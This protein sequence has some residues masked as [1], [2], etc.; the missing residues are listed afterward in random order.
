V[1]LVAA[2]ALL[3]TG[4][5]DAGED[6][7]AVAPTTTARPLGPD[8]PATTTTTAPDAAAALELCTALTELS[9]T[10]PSP[11]RIAELYTIIEATAPPEVAGDAAEFVRLSREVSSA[12]AAAGAPEVAIDVEAVVATLSPEAQQHVRDLAA[13]TRTGV[14]VDT[15]AGHFFAYALTA[16]APPG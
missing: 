10:T 4:C 15:P 9:T 1:A 12:F 11:E 5:G 7:D 3:L 16:C 2:L 6:D 8:A 14:P 13:M